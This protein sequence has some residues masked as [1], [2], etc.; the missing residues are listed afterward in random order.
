MQRVNNASVYGS[1]T[2]YNGEI[3]SYRRL[4]AAVLLQQ[5]MD[6]KSRSNK[7]EKKLYRNHALYWLFD[8]KEDFKM[9]CDFADLDW[10]TI[11]KK[12]LEAKERGFIWPGQ[13]LQP[14]KTSFVPRYQKRKQSSV[15][16]IVQL[17]LVLG[18]KLIEH[19][20]VKPKNKTKKICLE[21]LQL[22]MMF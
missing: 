12:C 18:G 21:N 20:P 16:Q 19:F 7:P 10:Q 15:V 3:N 1:E 11:R 5:I 22:Q 8:N 9:V 13:V 2:R 6:A 4:W 17:E 14:V